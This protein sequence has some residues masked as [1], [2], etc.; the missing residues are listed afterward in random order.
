MNK[1]NT[2]QRGWIDGDMI[3]QWIRKN[4]GMNV[5]KTSGNGRRQVQICG[6]NGLQMQVM[7]ITIHPN[8][9]RHLTV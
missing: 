6:D 1:Q 3:L 2:T 8:K 4:G 9:K 5:N 7:N